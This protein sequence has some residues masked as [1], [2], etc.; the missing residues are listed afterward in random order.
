MIRY[1][2]KQ[3]ELLRLWQ[4]DELKRIN[5]LEGSVSSG[6]TWVSLI[7][8]AF[9]VAT[10]PQDKLY[11]M[12]AKSLTTLKRNCL[13]LL[14]ELVGERNF[15][16]SIPAKEGY[17]FG[18]RVLFEGANDARAESK[19]RGM[20]LQG[21][22]C[23]ELTQFPEDFFAM[24]LSRLRVPSAKLIATTNPDT[25]N[26][27]LMERYIKR[28]DELDFLDV[29]FTIDDNTELP[30]DYV[31]NIKKEYTGVFYERFILGNWVVAEGL[32]YP[33]FNPGIH[34]ISE[35]GGPGTY[36]ISVDY[37]TINPTAMGLWR[38]C[39]G[40]AIM[41]REYYHNSRETH[42]QKTDEEYY[43]DLEKFAGDTPI[44]RI[45]IDPS[46]ASFKECI[47]RHKKFNI[48]DADNSVLDGIRFTGTLISQEKVKIHESCKN[49]I[50]EFS[51]YL[52]DDKSGEDKVIK[53]NDHSMDQMRYF[54]QT[55]RHKFRESRRGT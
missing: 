32:V 46:A 21:A 15:V 41:E 1:T 55:L 4:K 49:T 22:Y 30:Q 42:Q 26:H 25:P 24:L 29:K 20:T 6:K 48:M 10:M 19:I 13:I 54:C 44:Q 53:E 43:Q 38:L 45:I 39:N 28:A 16:F 12:C 9:W 5:L 2:P 40:T 50:K 37:G 34:L 51:A 52:W 35:R 8:W 7:L 23:D 18:R 3:R 27:W 31:E 36:Y 14:Q 17:L 33:M 11:L 47:R